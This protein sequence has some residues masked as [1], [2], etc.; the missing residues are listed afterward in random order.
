MP[1]PVY[2]VDGLTGAPAPSA[3]SGLAV[4]GALQLTTD[5]VTMPVLGT[6]WATARVQ[7][8][9]AGTAT[10]TLAFA[11]DGLGKNWIAA[12][13]AR[14]LDLVTANPS[15]AP[16]SSS[17]LVSGGVYEIVIPGNCTHVQA[18]CAA[19]G[20]A[21]SLTLL[22]GL[23]YV[24]GVPVVGVLFDVTSA[25]NTALD[26]G[27]LDFGGWA[28]AQGF[29]S[30]PALGA[31]SVTQIDDAGVSI[32]SLLTFPAA[33]STWIGFGTGASA[34]TGVISVAGYWA[35]PIALPKR[36]RWQTAAVAA[37]TSRIRIEVRR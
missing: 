12:P 20:T 17:V 34:A 3:Q 22:G 29:I 1:A 35:V 28:T 15:V 19:A 37:V 27:T 10:V 36:L 4:S 13:Y 2:I 23:P 7:V 25:V 16:L 32:G 8:A 31:G 5:T 11:S 24:P 14:R 33:A 18:Q 21:T 30:T 9:T 26:T 6:Q